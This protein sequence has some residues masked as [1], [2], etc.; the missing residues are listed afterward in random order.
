MKKCCSIHFLA[1]VAFK[2]SLYRSI[3]TVLPYV[4]YPTCLTSPLIVNL[5]KAVSGFYTQINMI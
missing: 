2:Y 5:P 4:S 1:S 3:L